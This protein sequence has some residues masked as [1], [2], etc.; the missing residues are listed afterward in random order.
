[1]YFYSFFAQVVVGGMA[2]T[3][4]TNLEF[5]VGLLQLVAITQTERETRART[6]TSTSEDFPYRHLSCELIDFI[7][8]LGESR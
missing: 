8:V 4:V 6:T 2:G 1:M 7:Y 5:R 3:V